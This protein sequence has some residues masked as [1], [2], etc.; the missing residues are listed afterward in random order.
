MHIEE[1]KWIKEQFEKLQDDEISPL[2]NLGSSTHKFRVEYQPFIDQLI[3]SP[4]RAK[5]LEI[6][7]SDIKKDEGVDLVGDILDPEFTSIVMSKGVKLILCSNMLE[8][9]ESAKEM[10]AAINKLLPD[11][12]L[13]MVTV[14][15]NYPLHMDPIDTGFRPTP[16]EI[17]NLFPGTSIVSEEIIY[18]GKVI[19]GIK[20]NPMDLLK[21]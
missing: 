12:G 2:V 19:D 11:N 15:H 4:L 9:V 17:C 6:I 21:C 1:A 20:K 18:V 7:H 5:S 8:H 14:P 13:L 10:A 3:F 16:S